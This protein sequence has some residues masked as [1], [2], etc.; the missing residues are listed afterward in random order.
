MTLYFGTY[1]KR[2]SEGI[3][4]VDFNTETGEL[5][6]RRLVATEPNPT[7][8]AFSNDH[9]LYTVG[10]ED[11]QGGL[12]A[13]TP[14]L[15]PINHAV[16]EGA[17]H[18]YVSVDDKRQLVYGANYHK[19]QVL[20]YKRLEN[21]GLALADCQQHEGSGPHPN[22]ASAHVHFADLTPDNYLVTCDLG[23]DEVVT[24]TVSDQGKLAPLARYQATPGAGPRHITFHPTAKIAYLICELNSTI[25]VLIYDG[26]GEFELMQTISTLPSDYTD[27]NGTA[28]IR[29]SSD[30]K[31]LYGSN[32]GHDSIAVYKVL[33]DASLELVEIV[34]SL[35]KTP[36][37]FILS[38]D[39][40]FVIV[41]H[42][43]SDNVS[44]FHR[45]SETGKLANLSS[46]FIVPE[47]VA[48]TF[49]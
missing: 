38:P 1:T 19:G 27:F 9:F 15:E 29:L 8:L 20:V 35:G 47:A 14:S 30:G 37:D 10:A 40:R 34:P 16:E 18:C 42:Q 12:A 36:R 4:A 5:S 44:V 46:D 43:D 32:R 6:N 31:F 2:A 24:Y 39:N 11:S 21:G 25:E 13:F 28:A 49:A 45:D 26:L 41:A 48:I 23:L 33:G 17:P 22:Q 3:Y 7:Y